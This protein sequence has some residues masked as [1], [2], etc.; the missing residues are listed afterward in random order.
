MLTKSQKHLVMDGGIIVA[1]A[2]VAVIL[3]A[4]HLVD[5]VLAKTQVSY[6][7]GSF[8]AGIFFT[9]VFT[10][11]PAT[12]ALGEIAQINGVLGV[13][14]FGAVG[15]L[16]GDLF[17]FRFVRDNIRR[18][19][20]FI[21]DALQ[22]EERWLKIH[23]KLSELRTLEWL[24]PLLG[25]LIIASPLPDELGLLLLGLSRVKTGYVAGLTFMLNFLGIIG[26]GLIA[27]SIG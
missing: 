9:S 6:L 5:L 22:R 8:I 4:T 17:I 16:L 12:V 23:R 27:R 2:V 3:V 7:I 20:D 11:L 10:S 18:D 14:F 21:I 24:I 15:S 26:I 25:A 19:L 1:S 13:A